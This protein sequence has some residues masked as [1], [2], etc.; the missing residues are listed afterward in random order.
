[1]TEA[2]IFRCLTCN[3]L[4]DELQW[5]FECHAPNSPEIER[6]KLKEMEQE[7]LRTLANTGHKFDL[8]EKRHFK[9]I[10]GISV[11]DYRQAFQIA[12][13]LVER[14]QSK[15]PTSRST[16]STPFERHM[17][18]MQCIKCIMADSDDELC[19]VGKL[20]KQNPNPPI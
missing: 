8:N 2:S 4:Y 9:R 11:D 3:K 16:R 20:L 19:D 18:D 10:L 14:A 15:L 17:V 12:T 5:K 1:M 6:K 7:A 13:N